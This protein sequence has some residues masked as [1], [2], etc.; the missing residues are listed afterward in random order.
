MK[1]LISLLIVLCLIFALAPA[2]Y[3]DMARLDE[4]D[5]E[6]WKEIDKTFKYGGTDGIY[7]YWYGEEGDGI[8]GADNH[9]LTCTGDCNC[10]TVL[11]AAEQEA[12]A[13]R[14]RERLR[15]WVSSDR[16]DDLVRHD[17]VVGEITPPYSVDE[18]D[19]NQAYLDA[20]P[21]LSEALDEFYDDRDLNEELYRATGFIHTQVKAHL[22]DIE[23]NRRSGFSHVEYRLM[24]GAWSVEVPGIDFFDSSKDADGKKFVFTRDSIE[25]DVPEY[26]VRVNAGGF[27]VAIPEDYSDK[28]FSLGLSFNKDGSVAVLLA[29]DKG[30]AIPGAVISA[31]L[32]EGAD[33]KTVAATVAD[34][35]LSPIDS[36]VE[37]GRITFTAPTGNDVF[38]L[39]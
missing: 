11:Y 10:A 29:D 27:V 24:N 34:D 8:F 22:G 30:E 16:G 21:E 36:V 31:V 12:A 2:A 3:A 9:L 6:D 39:K 5:E 7:F 4:L 18:E 13:A 17:L 28:A 32:P 26:D 20:K 25:G 37:G 23:K 14:D 15:V 38:A 35:E 33:D 1:K 19:A